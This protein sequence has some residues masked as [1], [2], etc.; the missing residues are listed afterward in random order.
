VVE[1]VQCDCD[2]CAWPTLADAQSRDVGVLLVGS[3]PAA[4]L[5]GKL[6]T[7]ATEAL[8]NP[9]LRSGIREGPGTVFE[10]AKLAWCVVGRPEQRERARQRLFAPRSLLYFR[11]YSQI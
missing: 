5:V 10:V 3:K 6:A 8:E 7:S 9:V 2:V 1:S 4:P 11:L